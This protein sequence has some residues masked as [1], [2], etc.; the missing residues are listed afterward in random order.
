MTKQNSKGRLRN[1]FCYGKHFFEHL[2]GGAVIH[3]N[4]SQILIPVA[5]NSFKQKHCWKNLVSKEEFYR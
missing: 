1:H 4:N 2:V 3:K 5:I